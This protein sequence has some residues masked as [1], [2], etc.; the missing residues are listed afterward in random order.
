MHLRD[1]K[2]KKS[3]LSAVNRNVDWSMG[4]VG[5]MLPLARG[6]SAGRKVE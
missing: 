1:C 5:S 6:Q 4:S 2:W 3:H